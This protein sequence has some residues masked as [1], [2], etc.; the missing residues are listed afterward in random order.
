LHKQKEYDVPLF[1][2][3]QRTKTVKPSLFRKMDKT[4]GSQDRAASKYYEAMIMENIG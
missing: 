1:F 4:K 2:K 3:R